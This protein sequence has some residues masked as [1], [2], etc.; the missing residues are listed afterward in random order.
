MDLKTIDRIVYYIPFRQLRNDVRELLKTITKLPFEV[1]PGDKSIIKH[2][3]ESIKNDN[4]F[5]TKYAKLVKGLD[6]ESA[7]IIFNM[8]FNKVYFYKNIDD[9]VFFTEEELIE[10]D[11]QFVEFIPQIKKINDECFVYNQYLLPINGFAPT[12][13]YYKYSMDKINNLEYLKNKNIIDAGGYI[14]DT[15]LLFSNYTNKNVYSFEPF[16]KNIDLMNKT[17]KLNDVSNIIPIKKALGDEN[18]DMYIYFKNDSVEDGCI[19]LEEKREFI[20]SNLSEEKIETITL[21]TFVEEN[22]IEVGL[23]KTD[24]EGFEQKFLKGAVNT[25]KKQKPILIISIY[26]NYSDFFDIKPMIESWNLGYK[27]KIG[28][29]S[30]AT[31]I[32]ETVLIAEVY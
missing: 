8:I 2:F 1:I 26:H 20:D 31:A 17:I 28:K 3:R 29:P 18:K 25:I 32:V 9:P 23:I 21:D 15:A 27:F 5:I 11:K 14:G 10:E 19:E 16:Q 22:N 6:D 7:K 12:T 30:Q 4:N 13:F 24:L